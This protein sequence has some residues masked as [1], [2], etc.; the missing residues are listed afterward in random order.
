[1][2]QQGPAR[3]AE[4][5]K[6]NSSGTDEDQDLIWGI[7]SLRTEVEP[8]QA[9]RDL[10]GLSLGFLPFECVDQFDGGEEAGLAAVMFDGLDAEGGRDMGLAGS[11]AAMAASKAGAPCSI[12]SVTA[13]AIPY[14]LRLREP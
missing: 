10:P 13:W 11:R 9:F 5:Q 8:G 1:M 3:G 12:R 6:P 4:R 14:I 2:E 7:N